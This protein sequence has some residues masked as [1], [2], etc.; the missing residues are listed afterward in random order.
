MT[1][2]S[3]SS[4]YVLGAATVATGLIAGAFYVFACAVMPALARSDDRV[5]VQVMRD[6]NEV[7]QNPVF[8]LTFLGAPVLT[9]VAAWQARARD[10][11]GWVRAALALSVLAFLVTVACNVPLNDALA[12]DGDPGALRE[13]FEDAWVAWNVVRAVLLTVALGLLVKATGSR[14]AG[15]GSRAPRTGS[16]APR[17]G[18]R[19][20]EADPTGD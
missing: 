1:Q 2:N 11:R 13:E 15:T 20:A 4:G 18:S 7:V 12:H 9:A 19:A 16:R 8:F 3:R 10:H 6:I 5:Y 14:A 17:T